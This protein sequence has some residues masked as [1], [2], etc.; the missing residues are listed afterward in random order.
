MLML[1]SSLP[2]MYWVKEHSV[3]S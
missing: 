1:L 2:G 3:M